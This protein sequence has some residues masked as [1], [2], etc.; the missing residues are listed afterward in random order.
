MQHRQ[1]AARKFGKGVFLA[2][3]SKVLKVMESLI[4]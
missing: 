1:A 2:A 4:Y 3:V